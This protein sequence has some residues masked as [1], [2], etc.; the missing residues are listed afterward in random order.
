MA[1]S[2]PDPERSIVERLGRARVLPV[3]T[4]TDP[5]TAEGAC[6]ALADAGLPCV[7]ITYR[8]AVAS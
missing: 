3:L 6:R 2:L 5:R 7:E 1:Q 4:V 8:T